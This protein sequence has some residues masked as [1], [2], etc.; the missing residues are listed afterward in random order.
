MFCSH[1]TAQQDQEF[2]AEWQHSDFGKRII[3]SA[4]PAFW[5]DLAILRAPGGRG[6]EFEHQQAMRAQEGIM[7]YGGAPGK[8]GTWVA[9]PG[10]RPAE[11]R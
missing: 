9:L 4:N 11:C 8:D 10:W 3:D 5:M 1:A 6:V 2:M 7:K